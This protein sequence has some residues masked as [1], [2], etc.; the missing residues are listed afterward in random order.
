MAMTS[1]KR[2]ATEA[3][4]S[5]P[6]IVTIGR[7]ISLDSSG[8]EQVYRVGNTGRCPISSLQG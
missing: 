2:W 5:L 1:F 3:V 7:F 4:A 6:S 8:R